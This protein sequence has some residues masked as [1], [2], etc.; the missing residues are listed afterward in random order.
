MAVVVAAAGTAAVGG[1]G[2]ART[3]EAEPARAA[4]AVVVAVVVG[5]LLLRVLLQLL[6]LL[7]PVVL[8]E[9]HRQT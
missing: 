3:V 2:P 4:V 5:L 9:A 8:R 7:L 1:V 6:P